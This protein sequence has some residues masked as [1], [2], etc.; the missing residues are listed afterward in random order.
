MIDRLDAMRVFVTA[1]NEGSL[2][3]AG[4][5]LA[6][7]PAAITR[8]LAALESHVGAQLI[9]RTSRRLQLTEA[10]ERYAAVCRHVLAELDEADLSVAGERATPHG[11]LSV[12]APVMFGT[13]LLRPIVGEF[14]RMHPALQI[15][16]LLLNR[17]T[18]LVD[19][20]I[21]VALRI[22]ALQDSTL[23]AFRVGEVRRVLCASP[24]YLAQRAPPK[25]ITDLADHDCIA[26]EPTSA[27]DIWSFPPLP[28]RKMARTVRIRPRLMVNAD[29]A[30]VSAAV[31]G[32]GIV[33]ILS[34]KIRQEV[35]DGRLVVLLPDD[36][37]PPV[38][39][40]LV[41]PGHRLALTKVRAFMDFAGQRLRADFKET[42]G[43]SVIDKSNG[44]ELGLRQPGCR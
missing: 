36:E 42:A 44:A 34:Y 6:R 21:D 24:R 30:A 29:E 15:R 9:H 40:H 31:D 18:N 11:V 14:L 2:A 20:G 27:E 25:T 41:A 1:L 17:V 26:I 4:Q 32:E 16:Y 19:E 10:G 13:R 38:P 39:V 33:R 5:R 43:S 23:I 3:R 37:P 28:G 7:S 8:A 35:R 22:S 12:T